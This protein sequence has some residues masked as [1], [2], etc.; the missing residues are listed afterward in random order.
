A[1]GSAALGSVKLSVSGDLTRTGGVVTAGTSSVTLDGTGLQSLTSIPL[2]SVYHNGSGT[3]RF[4]DS[5]TITTRLMV[6]SGA[7]TAG[8]VT[9]TFSA[10]AEMKIGGLTRAVVSLDGAT[11]TSTSPGVD[12]WVLRVQTGGDLHARM[13]TLFN[14]LSDAGLVMDAGSALGTGQISGFSFVTFD[15]IGV[16]GVGLDL[17]SLTSA[18]NNQLPDFVSEVRF[19]GSGI[20]VKAAVNTPQIVLRIYTGNFGTL[21]ANGVS[22]EQDPGNRVVWGMNPASS[23]VLVSV[24]YDQTVNAEKIYFTFN[25]QLL[26]GSTTLADWILLGADGITNLKAGAT[27]TILN[28]QLIVSLAAG[29]T[30]V[31]GI[32]YAYT[33]TGLSDVYGNLASYFGS[34]FTPTVTGGAT[35][36]RGPPGFFMIS[37]TVSDP[38]GSS[39]TLDV[40]LVSG[41]QRLPLTDAAQQSVPITAD[42]TYVFAATVTDNTART[43]Q[44]RF[45]VTVDNVAPLASV[46]SLV[47]ARIGDVVTLDGSSS[48]DGNGAGDIVNARWICVSGPAL[49]SLTHDGVT[50]VATFDSTGRPAGIY[51]FALN[52]TDNNSA[53]ATARLWLRLQGSNLIPL[54][55]AGVGGRSNLSRGSFTLRGHESVDPEGTAL[56]Y[57]WAQTSGP[58]GVLSNASAASPTFTPSAGGRCVFSLVVTDAATQTSLPAEVTWLVDDDKRDII[59]PNAVLS[60]SVVVSQD[61][62]VTLDGSSSADA[63]GRTLTYQ[64]AQT[65]GPAVSLDGSTKMKPQVRLH[66]PGSYTFSLVVS[67]DHLPSVAAT[68]TIFVVQNNSPPTAHAGN[69]IKT[70]VGQWVTLDGSGSRDP[71]GGVLH[72][73]WTQKEG[74]AVSF[75]ATAVRPTFVVTK[76]RVYTF[77]LVV[78]DGEMRSSPSTVRVRVNGANTVPEAF[79]SNNGQRAVTFDGLAKL[80]GGLSKDGD[81]QPLAF[82]NWVQTSGPPALLHDPES[83]ETTF[84]VYVEGFYTFD[85]YVDDGQDRS[86]PDSVTIHVKGLGRRSGAFIDDAPG[87]LLSHAGSRSSNIPW[88]HILVA[89]ALAALALRMIRRA[90]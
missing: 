23:L 46:P 36:T 51:R 18:D 47:D 90:G 41:P 58:R 14:S 65:S 21:S 13:G 72:Y 54:A 20:N 50:G 49:P 63:F 29:K 4:A 34:G 68:K 38:D 73:R 16:T 15:N 55:D 42:G 30:T 26:P 37:L 88:L 27:L 25:S 19:N 74:P 59:A 5:T 48:K 22:G 70:T 66:L 8:A 9:L 82:I 32:S 3:A 57:G 69:T 33:G 52:V 86:L 45:N 85:L 40:T 80:E 71:N 83:L 10:G 7:V 87:C 1:G 53:T 79:A 2:A 6:E 81:G 64:W 11:L 67:N 35:P 76:S 12:R 61:T 60:P 78:T 31:G 62:T 56:S 39:V 28:N 44:K 89:M 43:S 75:D 77:E 24:T 17:S 84:P